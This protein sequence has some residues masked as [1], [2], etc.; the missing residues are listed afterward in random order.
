MTVP[1]T[2]LWY[3]HHHEGQLDRCSIVGGYAVCRRCLVLYPI[4]L[5]LA[6]VIIAGGWLPEWTDLWIVVLGPLPMAVE[7]VGEHLAG[8]PYR[9]RRHLFIATT[10]G[11]ASGVA[12][13]RHLL[14]PFPPAITAVMV[15]YAVVFLA[16]AW[17][18]SRRQPVDAVSWEDEF[19]RSE[20]ERL[21]RLRELAEH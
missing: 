19:E 20:A 10:A 13:G 1:K 6:A 21:D 8:W 2:A 15:A 12:L 16:S 5:V 18:G 3:T 11:I 4:T 9:P 7:W 14:D 17:L